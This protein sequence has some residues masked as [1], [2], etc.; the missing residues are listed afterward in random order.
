MKHSHTRVKEGFCVDYR[1]LISVTFKDSYPLP[2]ISGAF[3]ALEGTHYLIS[4]P[5]SVLM[6]N[7]MYLVRLAGNLRPRKG[8]L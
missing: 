7:L 1:K 5:R 8:C 6:L 2:W 3:D 4:N